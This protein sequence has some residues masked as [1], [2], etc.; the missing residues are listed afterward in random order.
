MSVGKDGQPVC[1]RCM[2]QL[3]AMNIDINQIEEDR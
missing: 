3:K 1:D 2:E